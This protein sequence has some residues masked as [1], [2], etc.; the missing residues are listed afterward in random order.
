MVIFTSTPTMVQFCG[1]AECDA[2]G[3]LGFSLYG[4]YHTQEVFRVHCFILLSPKPKLTNPTPENL[5]VPFV[6]KG[7][8]PRWEPVHDHK[9]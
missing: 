8:K 6:K 4:F 1:D 5:L 9:V 2:L 3:G 7:S